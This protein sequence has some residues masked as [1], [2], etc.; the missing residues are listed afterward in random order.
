MYP[1]L[2]RYKDDPEALKKN[3]GCMEYT[4]I[5]TFPYWVGFFKGDHHHIHA[6]ETIKRTGKYHIECWRPYGDYIN[7]IYS[8]KNKYGNENPL[9][10]VV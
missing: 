8:A 3:V 7:K 4:K 1:I 2:M 6:Y 9:Y 5:D 10:W